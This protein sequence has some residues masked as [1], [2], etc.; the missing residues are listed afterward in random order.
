MRKF[1]ML[2]IV[3]GALAQAVP[4]G[5]QDE[6]EDAMTGLSSSIC[7]SD[8]L[9]SNPDQAYL[10]DCPAPLP[11]KVAVAPAAPPSP[12][13]PAPA[14]TAPAF[15]PVTVDLSFIPSADSALG[16][17]SWKKMSD[18]GSLRQTPE[19]AMSVIA[20]TTT[21]KA[22]RFGERYQAR[23]VAAL[24]DH[25]KFCKRTQL[26]KGTILSALTFVVDGKDRAWG[27]T[28]TDFTPEVNGAWI[29][30]LGDGVYVGRFDGCGNFFLV[31]SRTVPPAPP[32]QTTFTASRCERTVM[33]NVWDDSRLAPDLRSLVRSVA[34]T[35]R[36]YGFDRGTSSDPRAVSAS[37]GRRLRTTGTRWNVATTFTVTLRQVVGDPRTSWIEGTPVRSFSVTVPAG[38]PMA[39]P[40]SQDEIAQYA[41]EVS[42]D[43]RPFIYPSGAKSVI[44]FPRE[45]PDCPPNLQSIRLHIHTV[46]G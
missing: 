5:A 7:G 36:G 33:L 15:Q 29:C 24:S 6:A 17:K 11:V 45:W 42:P 13:P 32:Q 18:G 44:A 12:P 43:A 8:W 46:E 23:A 22:A 20:Q 35:E 34:S 39:L 37:L 40:I 27:T 19:S 10:Y 25:S 16:A 31:I 26:R 9:R 41:I 1:L 21:A 2:A 38:A 28:S 4:A 3:V 30:D 14:P